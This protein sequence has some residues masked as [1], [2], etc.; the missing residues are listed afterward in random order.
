MRQIS[1]QLFGAARQLSET[2]VIQLEMPVTS[3]NRDV[4]IAL[5]ELPEAQKDPLRALLEISVISD[6]NDILPFDEPVPAHGCVAVL[7]PVAGG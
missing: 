6:E 1:V 2:E 4:L 7:P 5:L 3:T